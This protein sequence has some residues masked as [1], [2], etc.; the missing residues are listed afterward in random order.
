[1]KK[2]KSTQEIG[3]NAQTQAK[4]YLIQQGLTFITQNY[5]CKRGEIDIIMKDNQQLVFVEV[6]YRTSFHY[7]SSAATIGIQKQQK[8]IYT[9]MRYLQYH[10]LKNVACRFDVMAMT[11]NKQANL[12]INWIKN[13]FYSTI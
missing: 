5:T 6:R 12:E 7:G 13:A 4:N 2:K 9:A 8:I 3:F 11:C 1:M 10:Q